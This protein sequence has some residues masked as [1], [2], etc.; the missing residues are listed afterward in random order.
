MSLS[1]PSSPSGYS[2][3]PVRP[4]S[5]SAVALQ[6]KGSRGSSGPA[7]VV[8]DTGATL[9]SNES[10]TMGQGTPSGQ[11]TPPGQNASLDLATPSVQATGTPA[12]RSFS[13]AYSQPS[14]LPPSSA[15]VLSVRARTPETPPETPES[16]SRR[17]SKAFSEEYPDLYQR[18]YGG[19]FDELSVLEVN[20]RVAKEN[21]EAAKQKREEEEEARKKADAQ[22]PLKKDPPTYKPPEKDPKE[23]LSGLLT[24]SEDGKSEHSSGSANDSTASSDA[25]STS[26]KATDSGRG[27]KKLTR[28]FRKVTNLLLGKPVPES[29]Q[30]AKFVT[31]DAASSPTTD[32]TTQVRQ[33]QSDQKPRASL[34]TKFFVWLVSHGGHKRI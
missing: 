31:A 25:A 2:I 20:R 29:T 34:L 4:R 7:S 6:E 30:E 26:S 18:E 3:G 12:V 23:D 27:L 16:W 19:A 5:D 28:R 1:P 11:T 21:T 15:E 9:A 22:N 32:T 14:I 13:A 10:S 8:S 33:T 17:M 24:P